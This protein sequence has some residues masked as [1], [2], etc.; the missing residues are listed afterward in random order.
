MGYVAMNVGS[1]LNL[2]LIR[3]LL[4]YASPELTRARYWLL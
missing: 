3:Y 2:F 4:R 1:L